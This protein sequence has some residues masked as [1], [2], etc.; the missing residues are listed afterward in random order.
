MGKGCLSAANHPENFKGLEDFLWCAFITPRA[1]PR[2]GVDFTGQRVALDRNR[3]VGGAIESDYRRS[4]PEH[5]TCVFQRTGNYVHSRAQPSMRRQK[6]TGS[7]A[8]NPALRAQSEPFRFRA[9]IFRLAAIG[10][11]A[12]SEDERNR[13]Y[14]S[15]LRKRGGLALMAAYCGISCQ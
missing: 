1:W 11:M 7:R 9:I 5:L 13:E 3:I 4:R 14:E 6:I 2:A 8:I 15:R 10:R 12:V